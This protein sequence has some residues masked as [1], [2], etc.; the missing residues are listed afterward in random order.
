MAIILA[1]AAGVFT[2]GSTWVGGVVP[3]A[4]DTAVLNGKNLTLNTGS[5]ITCALITNNGAAYGGVANG[6][7]VPNVTGVT[8][9]VAT[10][11]ANLEGVGSQPLVSIDTINTNASLTLNINGNITSADTTTNGNGTVYLP[12]LTTANTT[13]TINVVGDVIAGNYLNNSTLY[14][15]PIYAAVNIDITGNC[16]LPSSGTREG[17]CVFFS[18]NYGAADVTIHGYTESHRNTSNLLTGRSTVDV[19]SGGGGQVSVLGGIRRTSNSGVS[20]AVSIGG[21]TLTVNA[22]TATGNAIDTYGIGVIVKGASTR[23]T[24]VV[25]NGDVLGGNTLGGSNG[26]SIYKS[27]S[28]SATITINGSLKTNPGVTAGAG[29]SLLGR[30]SLTVTGDVDASAYAPSAA[31]R[32]FVYLGPSTSYGANV[33]VNGTVRG[34][35]AAGAYAGNAAILLGSS[36]V[37]GEGSFT[38]LGSVVAGDKGPAVDFGGFSLAVIDVRD[39][40]ASAYPVTAYGNYAA[41]QNAIVTDK[42]TIRGDMYIAGNTR[43]FPLTGINRVVFASTASI[44]YENLNGS[45]LTTALSASTGVVP[46]PADVRT[47]V[48]VGVTSG[49]LNVPSPNTVLKGMPVD[50]SVGTLDVFD[51]VNAMLAQLRGGDTHQFARDQYWNNVTFHVNVTEDGVAVVDSKLITQ[52][53]IMPGVSVSASEL[54]RGKMALAFTGNDNAYIVTK[55]L[56]STAPVVPTSGDFTV[57]VFIKPTQLPAAGNIAVIY[58]HPNNVNLEVTSDGKLGLWS[59]LNNS[60]WLTATSVVVNAWNHVALVRSGST[61][62]LYLNGVRQFANVLTSNNFTVWYYEH[63]FGRDVNVSGRGFYGYMSDMTIT[64]GIAR[65]SGAN[66]SVPTVPYPYS[67][68][69]STTAVPIADTLSAIRAKTDKLTFTGTNAVVASA[70]VDTSGFTTRFDAIDTSVAAV[71]TAVSGV[72]S[73]TD[74]LQFNASGVLAYTASNDY[75]ARFDTIEGLTSNIYN[76]LPTVYSESFE[77]VNTKLDD[78]QALVTTGGVD[79]SPIT[80]DL[81]AVKTKVLEIYGKTNQLVFTPVGVVA[82]AEVSISQATD[83]SARFTALDNAVEGVSEF[84]SQLRY[85]EDGVIASATVNTDPLESRLIAMELAISATSKEATLLSKYALLDTKLTTIA[86]AQGAIDLQP[87]T[88]SLSDIYNK[89]LL[90]PTVT[91]SSSFVGV[92]NK[93]NT[94]IDSQAN[95]EVDLTP[96]TAALDSLDTKVTSGTTSVTSAI[97][98]LQGTANATATTVGYVSAGVTTAN[99]KLQQLTTAVANIPTTDLSGVN[100]KLDVIQTT[101]NTAG[102]CDLNPVLDAL[103]NLTSRFDVPDVPVAVIPQAPVGLKRLYATCRMPSGSPAVG[104]QVRLRVLMA[105]GNGVVYNNTA[106]MVAVSDS[107]GLVV[108]DVVRDEGMVLLVTYGRRT[109]RVQCDDKPVQ[110]LPTLTKV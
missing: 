37:A 63:A 101:L 88:E 72:K 11:N 99:N 66:L 31:A 13:V 65:Y 35:G 28:Y 3:G 40:K 92:N 108:F 43:A 2:A 29:C 19:Y 47:G 26:G 24:A 104:E 10:F 107:D 82:D 105:S 83:Y 78:L 22:D 4:G 56:D 51:A 12:S 9:Y 21:A 102:D 5:T 20:S 25:I 95:V 62:S 27:V 52:T 42:C 73:K 17:Q 67:N 109:E 79:L 44:T 85:N 8:T 41:I 57:E 32:P 103:A 97:A 59:N 84:V 91:Y 77:G 6:R 71:N 93:L 53:S 76:T 38:C 60:Y 86:N 33:T 36:N 96:V 50:A 61:I 68:I 30:C 55:A 16:I 100:A 14:L 34:I 7:I 48:P 81:T 15:A 70:S 58:S 94:I 49:S 90:I 64:S 18:S 106:E 1:A 87:I 75:T 74:Q 54:F 89:V 69:G 46:N 110:Q 80:T 45:T 39:L 23:N 98:S